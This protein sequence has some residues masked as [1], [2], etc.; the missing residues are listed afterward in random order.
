R[1]ATPALLDR[2]AAL[3]LGRPVG[4]SAAQLAPGL[5]AAACVQTRTATGSPGPAEM[6]RQITASRQALAAN[7]DET[8]Q[9]RQRLADAEQRLAAA[10]EAALA[11]GDNT[12]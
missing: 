2:A 3:F 5:D 6:R 1:E 4:L 10:V 8:R 9:R 11:R 7:R 12:Q